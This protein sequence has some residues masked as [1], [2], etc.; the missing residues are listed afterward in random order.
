MVGVSERLLTSREGSAFVAR[1][2]G[3]GMSAAARQVIPAMPVTHPQLRR[4]MPA[5]AA[6]AKA[7]AKAK[8]RSQAAPAPKSAGKK[9]FVTRPDQVLFFMS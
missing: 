2:W 4:I 3:C 1:G 5:A 8:A 9:R 7:K 6:R